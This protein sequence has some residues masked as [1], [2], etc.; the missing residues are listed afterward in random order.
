MTLKKFAAAQVLDA[1]IARQGTGLMRDAHRH[2][3]NYDPKP[4]FLYVR[5]RAISSRTNDNFD[6]FPAEEIKKAYR[7]FVGKPVFVNHHNENH[8]RARGVI[9]DAALHEDV[10]PDGSPDTWAEVLMEVDAVN[11]PKLAQAILAGEIDRTSMGTDVA[12]SVCSVCN[13]KAST[14]LEYCQHIPRLKGKKVR[15]RTASGEQEEVLVYEKCYGLGFFENSLLVEQPADPTAYFLG[16]DARGLQMAA[17]KVATEM[18]PSPLD[19]SINVPD[20]IAEAYYTE[21]PYARPLPQS[22][23][24]TPVGGDLLN[25]SDPFDGEE[26]EVTWTPDLLNPG[27]PGHSGRDL[28]AHSK[29][30]EKV[31]AKEALNE[32]LAPA[33]VDTLRDEQCP[34]CGEADSYDG[35]KCRVCGFIRPP[36]EFMDPDLEK[37]KQVDLRQDKADAAA[38]PGGAA[39]QDLPANTNAPHG[40]PLE[41]GAAQPDYMKQSIPKGQKSAPGDPAAAG[42]T[43]LWQQKQRPKDPAG[44]SKAE[45]GQDAAGT[46]LW[47]QRT[48]RKSAG[49]VH[50][51]SRADEGDVHR[52]SG[53]RMLAVDR[54]RTA[55]RVRAGLD[56]REASSGAPGDARAGDRSDPGRDDGRS[57]AREGMQAQALREPR[58]SGGGHAA[59]EHPPSRRGS[60]LLHQGSRVHPGEH[61]DARQRPH[62]PEVSGGLQATLAGAPAHGEGEDVTMR[63]ALAALAEQ[64]QRIDRLEGARENIEQAGLTFEALF[65]TRDLGVTG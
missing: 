16:V 20:Y 46:P 47:K 22:L 49:M 34:V 15:R 3:F 6:H 11:F 48:R 7:T 27:D 21:H 58:P 35:D 23:E 12:F 26:P 44:G 64:Q 38:Q 25:P 19:P 59:G 4:G 40:H 54:P 42:S 57:R 9:V 32:T 37:A 53:H 63:P 17:S 45:P 41:D 24:P 36:A 39:P 28:L 56:R 13:N 52:G 5:S 51:S 43:P 2:T 31:A 1:R 65:T 10:N 61:S 29:V 30:I 33:K 18:V 55:E 62:L 50:T 8:R 60:G 14:P